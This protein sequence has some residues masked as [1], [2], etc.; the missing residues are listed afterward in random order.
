MI[1]RPRNFSTSELVCPE[2]FKAYGEIALSF[3]DERL[4][5]T[6]DLLRDQLGPIYVNNWDSGGSF[7]QRGF[8]CIQCSLV[9]DA[10]RNNVLYCSAHMR[11]QAADFDVKDMN[12]TQVRSWILKN[13]IKLPF[14]VRIERN[15]NWVHVD[16]SVTDGGKVIMFNA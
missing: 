1:Y 3:F 16:T 7:T 11:G 10:I 13:Q 5:M 4:V 14:P 9:K 15:T 2:V 8:R 6:L 12:A